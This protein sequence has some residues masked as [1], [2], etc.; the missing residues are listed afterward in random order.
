MKRPRF[1]LP[2]SGSGPKSGSVPPSGIGPVSSGIAQGF[3]SQHLNDGDFE[4]LRLVRPL[5]GQALQLDG[6]AGHVDAVPHG[7]AFVGG[8]RQLEEIRH[9]VQDALFGER[10]ILLQDVQFFIAFR[11]IDEDLGLQPGMDVFRQ[12]EGGSV[13]VHGGDHPKMRMGLDLDAGDDG[14][15]VA[16]VIQ[17]GRQAG[18]ALLA[19]AV[20]FVHDG[21]APADHGGDQ[22]RRHVAQAAFALD[23]GSNQ[24]ILRTRVQG[25]LQDVDIAPHALAGGVGERGLAHA[26]LAEQA[27]VHGQILIVHD[28]PG[29][30]QLPH[31][32]VLSH[33]LDRQFV[34]VGKVQG[35][36]FDLD[37][38]LPS[39]WGTEARCA[40]VPEEGGVLAGQDFEPPRTGRRRV[41]CC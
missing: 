33:P 38:H 1:R 34:R 41:R 22:R 30:Q 13:V 10:K 27:G 18:P 17:Q 4:S 39:L 8:V 24:Q 36:A 40:R 6:V 5:G 32:F 3:L 11:K 14:F 31:E 9:V 35:Y 19:H 12:L 20:A 15:H 16:P 29:G 7:V 28:H 23:H 21:D 26:G 2:K 37:G 25:G